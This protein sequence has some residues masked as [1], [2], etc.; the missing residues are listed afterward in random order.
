MHVLTVNTAS[1]SALPGV[2]VELEHPVYLRFDISQREE[3]FSSVINQLCRC[4]SMIY[5]S[6]IFN[7]P[8]QSHI[9]ATISK[10]AA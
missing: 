3:S 7:L 2:N 1:W 10:V 9:I 6:I 5:L 8:E 4:E